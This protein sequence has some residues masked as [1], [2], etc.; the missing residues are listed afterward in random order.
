[1]RTKNIH[2]V[3]HDFW[4]EIQKAKQMLFVVFQLHYLWQLRYFNVYEENF[5][6]ACKMKRIQKFSNTTYRHGLW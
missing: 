4:K 5:I 6:F 2:Q 3:Q 1:M